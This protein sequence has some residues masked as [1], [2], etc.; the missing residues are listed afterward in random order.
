LRT[1]TEADRALALAGVFQAAHL[2]RR[3]ARQGLA[4]APALAA[5]I[6]SLFVVDP[7]DAA[8][9]Y[10]GVAPLQ[11]GLR[12]LRQQLGERSGPRDLEIVRYVVGILHLER[13]LRR[14]RDVLGRIR[15][16]LEA[17]AARPEGASP[18]DPEVVRALAELYVA[19][20]S[21]LGPRIMVRGEPAVLAQPDNASRIR[22]LLFAGVRSAV[23]W[24]Q[25]GGSRL[26]LL[27][28]RRRLLDA[29][30]AL[31][32]QAGGA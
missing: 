22:A 21:T 2:V 12:V 11:E 16:G 6:A 4:D 19:T 20:I 13:R 15:E 14:R 28:G 29:A 24:R 7:P 26:R 27:L 25:C 23:L 9:V 10:G 1:P 8:S 31:A 5:S 18:T 32:G 17:I 30:R 3:V